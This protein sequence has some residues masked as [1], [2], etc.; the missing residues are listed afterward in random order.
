MPKYM[1]TIVIYPAVELQISE[2]IVPFISD[3]VLLLFIYLCVYSYCY[4]LY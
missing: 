1:K 4:H 3:S 2:N